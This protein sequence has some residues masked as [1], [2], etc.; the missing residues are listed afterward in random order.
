MK[1]LSTNIGRRQDN[2]FSI[3][4]SCN[5]NCCKNAR[6]PLS[7][8]RINLIKE[9]LAINDIK[10]RRPFE[11][12]TYFFPRVDSED[13]CIF[14]DLKTKKCK[15]HL[16]KPET[17]I[18]GPITFDINLN[19]GYIEWYLKTKNI[20]KLAGTL[21][22]NEDQ[23]RKHLHS[24]KKEINKLIKDLSEKELQVILRIDEPDTLKIDEDK[25]D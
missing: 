16:C 17:C 18:A 4:E 7:Q 12:R 10:I 6:P 19:N 1:D 11:K 14:F 22:R 15:I 5:S 24:A 3:C 9:Y 21:Y 2:F 25:L 20:C 13:Y 23:L 8:K